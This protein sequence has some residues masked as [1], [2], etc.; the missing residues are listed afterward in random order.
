MHYWTLLRYELSRMPSLPHLGISLLSKDY[1]VQVNLPSYH[2]SRPTALK[3]SIAPQSKSRAHHLWKTTQF[4]CFPNLVDL[5]ITVDFSFD[6]RE[7]QDRLNMWRKYYVDLY[8]LLAAGPAQQSRYPSLELL[9]VT[10]IQRDGSE[11]SSLNGGKSPATFLLPHCCIPSLKHLRI[12]SE[13]P[14]WI[15]S[16]SAGDFKKS[17]PPYFER[18]G[19]VVPIN[20]EM[21]TFDLP[22]VD[23]VVLWVKRLAMK[24][25]DT[26]CWDRF[27]EFNYVEEGKFVTVSRDDVERWCESA[28]N[29]LKSK[30]SKK[31]KNA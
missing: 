18:G 5:H 21:I 29:Q 30:A 16:D 26:G 27:S 10:I 2:P 14:H 11:Q 25:Q 6:V 9:D 15:L 7:K 22:C 12:R 4:L 17:H 24:M 28:E 1:L 31:R 13:S 20:L 23:G 19:Q 8:S 3:F